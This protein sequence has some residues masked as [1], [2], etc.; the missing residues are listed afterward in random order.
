MKNKKN[1][2][3]LLYQ[4]K[5]KVTKKTSL[6]K[7]QKKEVHTEPLFFKPKIQLTFMNKFPIQI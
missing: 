2:L 4:D 3:I 7:P 1:E 5:R 6:S